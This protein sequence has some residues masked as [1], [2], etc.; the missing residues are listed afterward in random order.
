MKDRGCAKEQKQ[1]P[2]VDEISK[3][4]CFVVHSMH[5]RMRKSICEVQVISG[6]HVACRSLVEMN[7]CPPC[8]LRMLMGMKK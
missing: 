4:R 8:G 5:Q 2:N 7:M 6:I 3:R 1:N